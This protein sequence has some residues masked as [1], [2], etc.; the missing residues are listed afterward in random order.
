MNSFF[1]VAVAAGLNAN[2]NESELELEWIW[3]TR[4]VYCLWMN[5]ATKIAS[6]IGK[7]VLRYCWEKV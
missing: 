3:R 6:A 5:T 7:N 4:L 1:S 2:I